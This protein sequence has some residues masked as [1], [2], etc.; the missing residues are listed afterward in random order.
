LKINDNGNHIDPHVQEWY[1]RAVQ[2]GPDKYQADGK[3]KAAERDGMGKI[4]DKVQPF[5]YKII[6]DGYYCDSAG[7]REKHQ[8]KIGNV[9]PVEKIGVSG[10]LA[11]RE[12]GSEEEKIGKQ[13]GSGFPF[14]VFDIQEFA[15]LC[16]LDAMRDDAEQ[17]PS[18]SL[19]NARV[20]NR[21]PLLWS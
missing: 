4:M 9:E 5:R 3:K 15:E 2:V 14:T 18:A 8:G 16:H 11:Y 10:G 20:M 1:Q 19:F 12:R 21:T 6:N 7:G 13:E 17:P